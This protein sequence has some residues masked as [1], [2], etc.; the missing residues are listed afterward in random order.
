MS[1]PVLRSTCRTATYICPQPNR[2]R[3]TAARH[4]A[5]QEDLLLVAVDEPGLGD[6]L[7]YEPSRGGDLFPHLYA[8][9]PL[10]AVRWV[11]PLPL[12]TRRAACLPGSRP[13][14][15]ALFP[16]AKPLLHALDP[17]TAHR[18][19][20]RSLALLPPLSPPRDD[21]RLAVPVLGRRSSQPDRLGR[22]LRQAMRG[23]GPAPLPRLRLRRMRGRR[24]EA[25]AGQSEAS[26]LPA[27][28]GRGDHQPL[29]PQQ[30][31]PGGRPQRLARR[32]GR[33]G[34]VGVNIGANKDSP[35]RIADYAACIAG[36]SDV[37][38]FLTINV[39]SPNTPGLRDLQGEAF[40]DDLLARAVETR[41]GDPAAGRPSSSRSRPTSRRASSTPSS[42]R[43]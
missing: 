11:K 23:A 41:D 36:L 22:G 7:R 29:R 32:K 24:A 40:L 4:F 19:T 27:A 33:P 2:S 15:G 18:L 28:G 16:L 30:R 3:E 34:I 38:D 42:R 9:L 6:A 5:G 10:A 35:D 39:S 8:P 1:L 25:P 21:P 17:E 14:I 13:M 37:A 43:P 20:I 31:R 26:R 12:G